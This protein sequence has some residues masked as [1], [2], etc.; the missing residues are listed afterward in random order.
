V[1]GDRFLRATLVWTDPPA[2]PTTFLEVALVNDL[3]LEVRAIPTVSSPASSSLNSTGLKQ[4]TKILCSAHASRP[5]SASPSLSLRR[6][7]ASEQQSFATPQ[8]AREWAHPPCRHFKNQSCCGL[9]SSF[10]VAFQK[11]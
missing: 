3:D 7:S 6:F 8:A 4:Q 11:P 1:A 10:E 2:S 5:P 9:G